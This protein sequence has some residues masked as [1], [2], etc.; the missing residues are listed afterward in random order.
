MSLWR[1]KKIYCSTVRSNLEVFW[2]NSDRKIWYLFIILKLE[3]FGRRGLGPFGGVKPRENFS[4]VEFFAK[5]LQKQPIF[6][7]FAKIRQFYRK[8]DQIS[9]IFWTILVTFMKMLAYFRSLRSILFWFC[10]QKGTRDF[11]F[12]PPTS[13]NF[14]SCF[15]LLHCLKTILFL[16]CF[17]HKNKNPL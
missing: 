3:R 1:E 6:T 13:L 2:M 15:V 9:A 17:V 14:C 12:V 16:F 11:C 4:K 8:F 7:I 5:N 10:A